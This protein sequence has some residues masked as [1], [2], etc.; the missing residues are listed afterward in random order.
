[1]ATQ[2]SDQLNELISRIDAADHQYIRSHEIRRLQADDVFIVGTC[3]LHPPQEFILR[4]IPRHDHFRLLIEP[5][6]PAHGEQLKIP[7]RLLR[8]QLNEIENLPR[9]RNLGEGTSVRRTGNL[10]HA[11]LSRELDQFFPAAADDAE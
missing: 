9:E 4:L 6:M 5:K 3:R 7:A 11:E 10:F 8:L 2:A 1:M